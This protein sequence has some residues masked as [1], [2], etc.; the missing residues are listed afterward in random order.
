MTLRPGQ[1]VRFLEPHKK[2]PSV[3]LLVGH[4]E[5]ASP[6]A[7]PSKLVT[8]RGIK[9]PLDA[10][11]K[12]GGEVLEIL[13]H[14][15]PDS[16]MLLSRFLRP[17][18]FFYGHEPVMRTFLREGCLVAYVGNSYGV[19]V[20]PIHPDVPVQIRN[21]VHA[22]HAFNRTVSLPDEYRK[23]SASGYGKGDF[24]VVPKF[25]PAVH[26][27]STLIF[28]RPFRLWPESDDDTRL[29]DWMDASR[30]DVSGPLTSFDGDRV[31]FDR[32]IEEYPESDSAS[33][34]NSYELPPDW[35][36]SSSHCVCCGSFGLRFVSVE[37]LGI[38]RH[39]VDCTWTGL[40]PTVRTDLRSILAAEQSYRVSLLMS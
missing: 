23:K 16:A 12:N 1:F 30:A 33:G 24:V 32:R 17:E 5:F 3:G 2:D 40:I 11:K 28:E 38:M 34:P 31:S 37:G 18:G 21:R 8:T 14:S 29:V 7:P 26:L 15:H 19:K 36:N 22:L 9:L 20:L 39:C 27:G 10:L 4:D 25:G 6:K 13:G 35:E